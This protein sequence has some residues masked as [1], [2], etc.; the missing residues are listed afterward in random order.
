MRQNYQDRKCSS[1]CL[2]NIFTGLPNGLCFNGHLCVVRFFFSPVVLG[3]QVVNGGGIDENFSLL[4]PLNPSKSSVFF[5]PGKCCT[6][7]YECFFYMYVYI[8]YL[9]RGQMRALNFLELK[10]EIV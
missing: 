1:A 6:N 9:C 8:P 4:A 2:D 5:G 10:S 3:T 7:V